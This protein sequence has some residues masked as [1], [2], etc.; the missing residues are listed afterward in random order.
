MCACFDADADRSRGYVF[1]QFADNPKRESCACCS[2]PRRH[3]GRTW[4]EDLFTVDQ[5]LRDADLSSP[6]AVIR[7]HPSGE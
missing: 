4:Q 7:P 6:L 1:S 2:S 3:W 5:E